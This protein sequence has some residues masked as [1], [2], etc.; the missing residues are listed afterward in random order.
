MTCR[1][2]QSCRRGNP[3]L[4]PRNQLGL[5]R[6]PPQ[7]SYQ[8][9][10]CVGDAQRLLDTPW[11]Q[12]DPPPVL[13]RCLCL[14][15]FCAECSVFPLTFAESIF[16]TFGVPPGLN[17][18]T[19]PSGGGRGQLIGE[20]AQSYFMQGEGDT[21]VK[22]TTCAGYRARYVLET[23]RLSVD[24]PSGSETASSMLVPDV[25]TPVPILTLESMST[26][27]HTA[28]SDNRLS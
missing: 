21:Y 22:Q 8:I 11:S 7:I 17:P 19:S 25:L 4:F 26:C 14:I 6:H 15:R 20:I 24:V 28:V 18:Q 9:Y 16:R 12:A 1:Q 13:P 23:N 2:G 3:T 27:N 5:C 10:D